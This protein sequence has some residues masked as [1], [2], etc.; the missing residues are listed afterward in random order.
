MRED[1]ASL[2][3]L[4]LVDTAGC[5]L[6]ELTAKDSISRCNEGE[7]AIVCAQVHALVAA[8]VQPGDIAVIT[9][10]NL[11]VELQHCTLT[12]REP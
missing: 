3:V 11:Q 6:E 2:P 9:P 8:G 10:Y 4:L 7:A 5:G 1:P 12:T